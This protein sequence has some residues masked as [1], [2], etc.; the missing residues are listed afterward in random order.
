MWVEFQSVSTWLWAF[1]PDTPV[2]SLLKIDSQS[3]PSGCGAVL[4]GHII[5]GRFQGRALSRQHSSFG[6]TSLSCLFR[7]SVYDCEKGR[8]ILLASQ[9]LST[10]LYFWCF[11]NLIIVAIFGMAVSQK[12]QKQPIPPF[13]LSERVFLNFPILLQHLGLQKRYCRNKIGMFCS[14]LSLLL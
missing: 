1:P 14:F 12:N 2:S 6:P 4:W 3:N 9:I 13:W 7:N 8:L 5:M 11:L 10:R